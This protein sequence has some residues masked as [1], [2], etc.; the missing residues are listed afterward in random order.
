MRLV[1]GTNRRR[2]TEGATEQSNGLRKGGRSI[3]LN[4]IGRNY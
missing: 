4:A 2:I 3:K 1:P